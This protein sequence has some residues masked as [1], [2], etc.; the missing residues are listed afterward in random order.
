MSST[1]L[2]FSEVNWGYLKQRHHFFAEKY[3]KNNR[4]IYFGKIGL[5][6]PNLT[7]IINLI[8]RKKITTTKNHILPN[9]FF[10]N[11]RFLPPINL[12]FRFYNKFFV[13]PHV[14]K[15]LKHDKLI[16]H[17]YQPTSLILD[18]YTFIKKKNKKVKLVYDCVQDYRFHPA[19]TEK[20][21]YY[22][23]L[24]S[25]MSDLI[26]CDSETNMSRLNNFS[27][28]TMLVPPGVDV[29]K[30]KLNEKPIKNSVTEVLY[31]GNIRQDLDIDLINN[32]SSNSNFNVTLLGLLN[33]NKN[34][35]SKKIKI[36]DSVDYEHLPEIIK[37]YNALLLPYD[38]K[39]VFTEAIIPAKFFECLATGL[40]II[41][42]KMISTQKYHHLL[43]I[44][45]DKT[46]V[47][48]FNI[49]NVTFNEKN[50]REK[51]ISFSSWKSR[52]E[53]YYEKIKY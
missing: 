40:P 42:T 48:K 46:N 24:L 53:I 25:K 35:F 50:E 32:L 1:V 19:K 16:I 2:F 29:K 43:N 34:K 17:F 13:I 18:I 33:I 30:F 6:Y 49:K 26:I 20:I 5:R 45:D 9:L 47:Q 11:K 23:N 4:V 7:E 12:F 37:N 3:A 36:L 52:F 39:N 41:S 22:E 10:F 44:I 31:Y 8:F 28:K 38:T 51:I 21:I 15:T 14:L 27:K